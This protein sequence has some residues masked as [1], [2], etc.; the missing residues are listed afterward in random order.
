[1]KRLRLVVFV[2]AAAGSGLAGIIYYMAQ[3]R[4]TPESGLIPIGPQSA[5]SIVMVGG[6][7][8]IE[9]PI[10]GA[11][12]Y[13]FATRFLANTAPPISWCWDS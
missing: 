5:F 13:F 1:V 7:G 9:G 3:L 4:I 10:I 8:R 2:L 11:L 6:I 12:L